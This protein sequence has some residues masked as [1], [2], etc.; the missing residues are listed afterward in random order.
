[1][2]QTKAKAMKLRWIKEGGKMVCRHKGH[3]AAITIVDGSLGP[4]ASLYLD[5]KSKG[6]CRDGDTKGLIERAQSICV[7][8]LTDPHLL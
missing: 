5:G 7:G 6:G 2:G 1:M 4:Y 8:Y 3:E